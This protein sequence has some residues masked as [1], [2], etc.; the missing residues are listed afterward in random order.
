MTTR[1][2]FLHGAAATASLLV[3]EAV[4]KPVTDALVDRQACGCPRVHELHWGHT[5]TVHDET[6]KRWDAYSI[7]E[8]M[9][10]FPHQKIDVADHGEWTCYCGRHPDDYMPEGTRCVWTG[11]GGETPEWECECVEAFR[12]SW[13]NVVTIDWIAAGKE[14][15]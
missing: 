1:R 4:A 8:V 14:L 2:G 13:L 15:S 6:G 10:H 5:C 11:G 12:D 9:A 3:C 7:E